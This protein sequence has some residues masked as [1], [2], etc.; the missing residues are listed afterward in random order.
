M[1]IGDG[2]PLQMSV[3]QK[4]EVLNAFSQLENSSAVALRVNY[5]LIGKEKSS[6][7]CIL[8]GRGCVSSQK[9]TKS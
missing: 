5:M 9:C 1:S 2:K 7:K 8:T 6:T 4:G 3:L